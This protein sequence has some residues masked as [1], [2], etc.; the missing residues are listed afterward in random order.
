[1]SYSNYDRWKRGECRPGAATNSGPKPGDFPLGS[2][3]SRAAARNALEHRESSLEVIQVVL[4]GQKRPGTEP[5]V[6]PKARRGSG[7][8]IEFVYADDPK[9]GEPAS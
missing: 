1:M 8:A 7:V 5:R 9:G 2:P 4:V 6:P 3:A